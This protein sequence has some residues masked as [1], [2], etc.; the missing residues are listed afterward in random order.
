MVQKAEDS[1]RKSATF[2]FRCDRESVNPVATVSFVGA[3][4]DECA[5]LFVV[6]SQ[7]ACATVQPSK[8][9]SVGPGG[10]FAIIFF[11]TIAVYFAGGVFYQRTVANARGWRQLPNYSLWAGMWNVI[12]VSILPKVAAQL[13]DVLCRLTLISSQDF[14]IIM[15]S[16]CARFLPSRRGYSSLSISP[17]GRGMGRSRED[18]DRLIGQLDE[19]WDD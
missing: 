6:R 15:T 10:V 18:E 8:P 16:S 13:E 7:H 4:P 9:G 3:D 12:S 11:I 14:F 17:N 1:R 2:A 5:Y 19:E